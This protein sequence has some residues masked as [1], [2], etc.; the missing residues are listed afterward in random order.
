VKLGLG[1]ITCQRVP[2]DDRTDA[3]LYEQ[4]IELSVEAERLGF[5]SVWTTEHHFVDDAYMPS[6]LPLSAAIAA[7]TERI[8][9]GTG[10]LLAP[11]HDPVRL[12]E[13]VAT[14][15]L[16]SRGRFVLGLGLGW[17]REEFEGLHIPLADRRG[18]M[19]DAI[20]ICRQAWGDGLV[21]GTKRTPY[22]GVAVWPKPYRPGGPPIWIGAGAERAVRRAGRV[23]DGYMDGVVL[24][25]DFA[26]HLG[27][28]LDER[29]RSD[30]AG[31]PFEPSIY[32]PTL[33]WE[34]GDAWGVVR[35]HVHYLDWKYVD[36]EDA[37][38]RT[39]PA[40][41]PAPPTP[42]Q[43]RELRRTMV[44]GTPD[45]VAAGIRAYRDVA[46]DDLHYIA[47]LYWPG[48]PYERQLQVLRIFGERVA[49]MLR[50]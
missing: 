17:R 45:E 12:A 3:D 49:P 16:I 47:Q 10:L 28:A 8:E 40:A 19:L 14:V 30:R 26:E 33:A 41:G 36:M 25:E 13:D 43:E 42:D 29:S 31:L 32:L 38:G 20:E 4:A 35:D 15:D 6:L 27:W 50:S 37:F 18:R 7:R 11:L 23:A 1:L 39:E 24:P 5:D 2:G 22:P 44:C 9:I 46:G 48:M 34:D 21:T